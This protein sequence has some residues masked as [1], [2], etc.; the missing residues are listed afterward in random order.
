M[1][2][3]GKEQNQAAGGAVDSH[4]SQMTGGGDAAGGGL[5]KQEAKANANN[6]EKAEIDYGLSAVA[7]N[8]KKSMATMF[9]FLFVIGILAYYFLFSGDDSKK[10]KSDDPTEIHAESAPQSQPDDIP[11]PSIPNSDVPTP[12][13]PDENSQQ[14]QPGDEQPKPKDATPPAPAANAPPG[15]P[16]SD[17]PA[18]NQQQVA[19][20]IKQQQDAQKRAEQRIKSGIMVQGGG[21]SGGDSTQQSQANLAAQGNFNPAQTS[22]TQAQVT[23]VGNFSSMIAQ[24]KIMDAVLESTIVSAYPGTVRALITQDVYSE[25]GANVLVPKGSRL[26]G[27]FSAGFAAGQNRINVVWNRLIMPNGYDIALDSQSTGPEGVVGVEGETHTEIAQTL[28]NALLVSTINIAFAKAAQSLTNTSSQTQSTSTN[29]TG[30]TT[31]TGVTDPTRDAIS[32]ATQSFNQSLQ[33]FVQQNFVVQ[34]FVS[35]QHGTRV[36]VFVNKDLLFPSN[37]ANGINLIQ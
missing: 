7:K 28:A 20:K 10:K 34:P 9:V 32:Q 24:G 11:V 15:S 4:L 23:K 3:D 22:A 6:P 26:L 12:P 14:P 29:S 31:T 37:M 13:A 18:F 19:N 35:V 1:A 25:K 17:S 5:N 2:K 21:G 33:S 36:K 16:G 27:T 8:P 30:T